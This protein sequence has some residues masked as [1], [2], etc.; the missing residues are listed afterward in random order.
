MARMRRDAP[1]RQASADGALAAEEG[2]AEALDEMAA[3]ARGQ[4][5]GLAI[6][7]HL[8]R[9]EDWALG[10]EKKPG[11]HLDIRRARCAQGLGEAG[12]RRDGREIDAFSREPRLRPVSPKASL[13][14]TRMAR[15]AGR[16]AAM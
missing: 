3:V 2:G 12:R 9:R 5:H 14:S 10:L 8:R 15:L 16:C 6:E 1:P 7:G 4:H 13:S 11:K